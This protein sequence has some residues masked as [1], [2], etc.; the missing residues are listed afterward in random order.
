M[1]EHI[2]QKIG[3]P[4]NEAKIYET[5]L[6]EGELT[7]GIIANKSKVHRRNVYD[8]LRKLIEKELVFEIPHQNE[9]SY[10]AADPEKLMEIVNEKESVIT[11]L[12]PN[13]E[14][15]YNNTPRNQDVC[16]YRGTEAR[17]NEMNDILRFGGDIYF[18]GAKGAW[19]HESLRESFSSFARAANKKNVKFHILFD[20]EMKGKQNEFKQFLKNFE[21]KFLPPSYSTT[22]DITIYD[23]KVSISSGVRLKS[24]DT[25]EDTFTVTINKPVADSMRTWFKFLWNSLS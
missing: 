13:L 23:N 7:V 14:K 20:A 6:R 12:M 17:K 25:K 9:M 24:F 11:A 1:Y 21:C 3:L 2:L 16:I 22:C 15:I 18:I 10:R 5:L 19:L 8:S 4:R